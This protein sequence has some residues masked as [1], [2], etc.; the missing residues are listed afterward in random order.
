VSDLDDFAAPPLPDP[1]DELGMTIHPSWQP[2]EFR[3]VIG[4]T[5]IDYDPDK[6]EANRKKHGYSLES[7]VHL[8]GRL[9]LPLPQP[10]TMSR[11]ASTAGERRHEHVTVDHH[12]DVVF[13]VTT[14]RPEETIRIISCRRASVD[15][16]AAFETHT[17]HNGK[18]R[19]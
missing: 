12:G 7:A 11:D 16:R 6:E 17:G 10:P 9:L 18:G 15:E 13:L 14:M 5:Q 19:Q 2:D 1:H 8:L 4:S 3:L